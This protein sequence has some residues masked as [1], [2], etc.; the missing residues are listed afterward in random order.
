MP[1]QTV[2]WGN[3]SQGEMRLIIKNRGD[4]KHGEILGEIE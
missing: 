2:G 1:G 4:L 3:H